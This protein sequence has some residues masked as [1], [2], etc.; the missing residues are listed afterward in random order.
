MSLLLWLVAAVLVI[1][2]FAGLVLPALPGIALIFF[3]LVVAAWAE[4]FF[5]VG[6]KTITVLALLMLVAGLIDLLSGVLGAKK[7]GAGRYALIGA[8][9]G[10]VCGLFFGIPGIIAG[11]FLGALLGELIARRGLK[12][13]GIAAIGTWI[14]LVAGSAMK[15]AIAFTM[16][17][18]FILVRFL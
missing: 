6:W 14:G 7:F 3:G 18:L 11:P 5:Y 16:L 12:D 4:H 10:A 13:A 9:I 17:G 1:T 8:G 15:I 2:G